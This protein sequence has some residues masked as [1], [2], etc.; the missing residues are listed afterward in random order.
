MRKYSGNTENVRLKKL[1]VCKTWWGPHPWTGVKIDA[2]VGK[3]FS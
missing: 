3:Q 1:T 2:S